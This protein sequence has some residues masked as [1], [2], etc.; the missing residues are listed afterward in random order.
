MIFFV[1]GTRP[2]TIKLF[3][4][5]K[6]AEEEGISYKLIWSGQHYDYEMSKLFF[7][8]LDLPNPDIYLDVDPNQDILNK[9]SQIISSLNEL[10][11]RERPDA[12]YGLGDTT[13][14]LAAAITAS[15]NQIP[16]IHD[17]AGMRSFDPTMLE[18][19]N[20]TV[21]DRIAT[22]YFA[23]TKLSVLNLLN[24]NV[25]SDAI[26]LVGSTA[27]DAL[28]TVINNHELM[29]IGEQKLLQEVK[30]DPEKNIVTITLHRRENLTREKLSI[31]LKLLHLAERKLNDLLFVFPIHPHTKRK[32]VEHNLFDELLSV[33]NVIITKPLGYLE[34]LVLSKNSDI[35]ITDSGGVQV[36][37]FMLGKKIL[38]LRPVT[39]WPETIITG[40]NL[41]VPLEKSPEEILL[42]LEKSLEKEPISI[43]LEKSPVG[44]GHSSKRIIKILKNINFN[45]IKN[46]KVEYKI[47]LS[48]SAKEYVK[49]GDIKLNDIIIEW[50]DIKY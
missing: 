1:I 15:Y 16:F 27:V 49:I 43:P 9:L 18:E 12:I 19:I 32:L 36:E 50:S 23:P 30:I 37:A 34:F 40:H 13:T 42:S 44:D 26:Y 31:F 45:Y 48:T 10:I 14:T 4:V 28:L 35:I 38:T 33:N 21:V 3:P 47:P 46:I 2:E 11:K 20:R 41:L 6:Q 8:E 5:I 25:N 24:E 22:I 7:Q 39:E 29:E 17:E